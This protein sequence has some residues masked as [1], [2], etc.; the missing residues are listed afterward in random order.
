[1]AGDSGSYHVGEE[2]GPAGDVLMSDRIITLIVNF[3]SFT[4][5]DGNCSWQQDGEAEAGRSQVLRCSFGG[6]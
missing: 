3:L 6:I 4:F 5:G 2:L 1:M